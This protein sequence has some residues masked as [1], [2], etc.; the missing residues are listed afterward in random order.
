MQLPLAARRAIALAI[1]L[2]FTLGHVQDASAAGVQVFTATLSG[3]LDGRPID[4][5]HRDAPKPE[6]ADRSAASLG[7]LL[8]QVCQR[9]VAHS[10]HRPNPRSVAPT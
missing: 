1:V 2:G 7:V 8:P 3:A 4:V 5:V 10:A 6:L 9:L